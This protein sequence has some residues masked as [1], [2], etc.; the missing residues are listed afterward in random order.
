S[1]ASRSRLHVPCRGLFGSFLQPV[2]LSRKKSASASSSPRCTED[3]CRPNREGTRSILI[4]SILFGRIAGER[5]KTH[6]EGRATYGSKVRC[7]ACYIP[8]RAAASTTPL[9][10]FFNAR[11]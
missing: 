8:R 3:A 7:Y 5:V 9:A 10:L 1:H 2:A 6:V 4:G 11:R